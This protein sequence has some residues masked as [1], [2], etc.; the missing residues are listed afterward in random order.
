[1]TEAADRW[2]WIGEAVALAAHDAML[3][4][5]GGPAGV[6]DANAMHPALARPRNLV[7]YGSP[8]AAALA[9]AYAFGRLRNHLFSDGNKRTGYA[10][11][12]LFLLDNGFAFTGS[13]IE[14]SAA[15]IPRL[16]RPHSRTASIR[17]RASRTT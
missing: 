4:E 3:V 15:A 9:A 8:D 1:M 10:L 6:R 5:F 13:D 11:A 7:A 14:A 12:L 2:N 17:G 16:Y